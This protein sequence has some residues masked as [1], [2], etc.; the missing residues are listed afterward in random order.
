VDPNELNRIKRLALQAVVSDDYLMETLVLKGGNAIDL[1]YKVAKRASLDLDFSMSGDFDQET[2]DGLESRISFQL[3]R[4]FDG[5]GFHV[6]DVSFSERPSKL[7]DDLR[8]IW[9]G[10]QI[11][12]KVISKETQERLGEDIEA[13][14]RNA[15]QL[16]SS[17]TSK[18]SIE[19]SR[20]E[21]CEPKT[22][23]E[24]DGY[25][26][27]VYTPALL[28]I[29]KLRAICQQRSDYKSIIH[30]ATSKGRARDFFDIC[31][32]LDAFNIDL[33][34]DDNR[35]LL[36]DVFTVKKVP[37]EYLKEIHQDR[38]FHRLD[39]PSIQDTVHPETDL[40][41]FDFY[42]D[43]VLKICDNL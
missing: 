42:F 28:V 5:A 11:Q 24:L 20:Y 17:V 10:Y 33:N 25:T 3:S 34:S 29:E 41:D 26:I 16:G 19:I 13:Q 12:F 37:L 6:F 2:L 27:F 4:T 1:I 14:R 9:G 22:A 32:L 36:Q 35:Q 43:K 23:M 39:F 8:G 38:D 30:S 40:R 21:Q 31:V 15:I 18:F 7:P